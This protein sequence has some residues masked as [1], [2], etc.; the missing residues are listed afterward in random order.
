MLMVLPVKS[1]TPSAKDLID[2]LSTGIAL[3]SRF[4]NAL[5]AI[6]KQFS[7]QPPIHLV[8]QK[9]GYRLQR[10]KKIL[11][12]FNDADFYTLYQALKIAA[13]TQGGYQKP[14]ATQLT[15][16][17]F[18][19]ITF[20]PQALIKQAKANN[21]TAKTDDKALKKVVTSLILL[22]FFAYDELDMMDSVQTDAWWLLAWLEV[23]SGVRDQVLLAML[24]D[25]LG[26]AVYA[27]YAAQKVSKITRQP[28]AKN[29]TQQLEKNNRQPPV[30]IRQFYQQTSPIADTNRPINQLAKCR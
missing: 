16:S 19:H 23:R 25:N 8:A 14:V 6:N 13:K 20:S 1:A 26:Y 15:F 11:Y 21:I 2:P 17:E 22:N 30:P 4:S 24:A 9:D 18:K 29:T 3:D 28:Q 27:Q 7:Q 10:H 12:Q 5:A